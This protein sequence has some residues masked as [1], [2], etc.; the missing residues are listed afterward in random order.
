M[1][2]NPISFNIELPRN[3]KRK[4]TLVTSYEET[5]IAIHQTGGSIWAEY[6]IELTPNEHSTWNVS[7]IDVADTEKFQYL[8][9]VFYK[10]IKS[11]LTEFIKEKEERG[12]DLGGIDFKIK[13]YSYHPVDSKP[14]NF[15]YTLIEL[16]NRLEKTNAF[17]KEIIATQHSSSFFEITEVELDQLKEYYLLKET[18]IY[19]TA[20]RIF[21]QTIKLTKRIE[22]I[23]NDLDEKRQTFKVI[24]SPKYD[25]RIRYSIDLELR[26]EIEKNHM[27]RFCKE[28]ISF[29]NQILEVL[30][31]LKAK[32]YNLSGMF[33]LVVPLFDNSSYF[34][35][36][37]EEYLKWAIL[38][39]LFNHDN[40]EI[41]NEKT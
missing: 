21:N 40:I 41:K 7:L 34:M 37:N 11:G 2:T 12:I 24:L 29:N 28:I 14:A 33:I 17:Q 3:Y 22:I 5:I 38:N 36:S 8:N 30:E 1:N 39:V 10:G 35:Q 20:P 32:E 26:Y 6:K 18:H 19:I 4:T 9:G 16:L 25:E 15:Q 13:N 23:L 27:W 31:T